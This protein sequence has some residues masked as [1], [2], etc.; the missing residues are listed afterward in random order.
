M[1]GISFIVEIISDD[2]FDPQKSSCV[3]LRRP[4]GQPLGV[5]DS[6]SAVPSIIESVLSTLKSPAKDVD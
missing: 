2:V 6:I 4:D 5:L 1:K 3:I